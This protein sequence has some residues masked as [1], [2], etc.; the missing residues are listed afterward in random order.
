[1]RKQLALKGSISVCV[2]TAISAFVT[3]LALNGCTQPEV[4]LPP[5]SQ[6]GDT[7][8]T[9]TVRLSGNGQF[10]AGSRMIIT[11]ADVSGQGPDSKALAGDVV[12][13]SQPDRNV[14]I[15]I[16]VDGNKITV[17]RAKKVCGV[18][19]KVV[20]G[21][22]IIYQSHKYAPYVTGQ[23]SVTVAVRGT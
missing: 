11:L 1:M 21:A 5:L 2:W 12:T 10:P 4:A 20:R 8:L 23:S 16:P 15:T 3:V 18:S 13:L 22:K 17:C 9:V 6:K 7:S 19:V 14:R